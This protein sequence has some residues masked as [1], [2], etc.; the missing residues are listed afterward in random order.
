MGYSSL[1]Q[2][3]EWLQWVIENYSRLLSGHSRL[4]KVTVGHRVVTVCYSWLQQV[5]EWVQW[6]TAGYRR[7]P[8]SY[9]GLQ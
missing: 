5:T 9:I 4:K 1:Q 3:T 7:L 2:V 6:V 8:S